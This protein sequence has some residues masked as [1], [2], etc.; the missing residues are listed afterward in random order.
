M[1]IKGMNIKAFLANH[2]EKVALGTIALMLLGI[3]AKEFFAGNWSREKRV[4]AEMLT[5]IDEKRKEIDSSVWPEP[6]AQ[7]FALVDFSE[8]AQTLL[9]P[10]NVSRYDLSTELFVPLY[11]PKEKAREPGLMVVEDL[12]ADFGHV[13]LA[14]RDP[15]AAAPMDTVANTD[16]AQEEMAGEEED[17]E[18][19]RRK[20]R[21]QPG[22]PIGNLNPGGGGMLKSGRKDKKGATTPPPLLGG[23][24]FCSRNCWAERISPS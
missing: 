2:I 10:I 3:W 18:F 21:A 8:R 24:P 1:S 6:M 19:S 22:G 15:D 4:P 23:K 17:E 16:P 20:D 14:M 5:K 13:I 7:P 9:S 12:R 11:K